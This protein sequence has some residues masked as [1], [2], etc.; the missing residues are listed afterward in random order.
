M[1]LDWG[2]A[3]GKVLECGRQ[4]GLLQKPDLS[5]WIVESHGNTIILSR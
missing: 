5:L 3:G 4:H 2:D 1:E